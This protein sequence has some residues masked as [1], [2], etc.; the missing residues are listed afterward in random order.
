MQVSQHQEQGAKP[1][2]AAR[3]SHHSD[4][5]DPHHTEV[6]RDLRGGTLNHDF[7]AGAMVALPDVSALGQSKADWAEEGQTSNVHAPA[8]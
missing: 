6:A 1:T 7:F 3:T 8:W 2:D 5:G 4:I